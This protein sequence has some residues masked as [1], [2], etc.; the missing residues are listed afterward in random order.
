MRRQRHAKIVATLGPASS[1]PTD[2]PRAVRRRRRRVPLQ[3]Q[4]RQPRRSR[5]APRMRAPNRAGDRPTDR[6]PA[7]PAGPEAARRHFR[8]RA[9]QAR[10]R[11]ALPPRSGSGTGR[12]QARTAAASGDLRRAE[13]GHRPAARRRQAP[14][15]GRALRRRFRRRPRSSSAACCPTARASTCPSVVL[16]ISALTDKDRNDLEF[17]LDLGVD[18]VALSFVQRPE[19]VIEARALDRRPRRRSSPRS[20]SRRRSS[21]S[22]RSS[23]WPTRVMVARGDLGVEM[24]PEQVPT[25]QKRIVRACREA[26]KPVIVATQMLES[27]IDVAGADPRRGVRRRHRDLRRR[28]RGDAVGRVGRRA[29]IRVEAVAMMDR[30][31]ARGRARP[32]LPP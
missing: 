29:S 32:A 23:R 8:R 7:R 3:F 4:P 2:D 21:A 9:G 30:I 20:R 26:G 15:A 16:P 5:R 28:R 25:I 11:R 1:D 13:A 27:M 6:D 14:P 12:R 19:D 10:G 22:T 17:G 18:W 31:I 24:P